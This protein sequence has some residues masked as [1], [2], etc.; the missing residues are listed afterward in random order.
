MTP[1]SFATQ[2]WNNDFADFV[3][4]IDFLFEMVQIVGIVLNKLSEWFSEYATDAVS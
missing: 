3:N 4:N 2:R 1:L